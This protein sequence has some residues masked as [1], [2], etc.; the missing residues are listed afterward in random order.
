MFAEHVVSESVLLP[1]VGYVEMAMAFS[2]AS[3][4]A[5]DGLSFLRRCAFPGLERGPLA[6]RR[7]AL[8]YSEHIDGAFEIAS[9][10]EQS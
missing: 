4:P 6:K 3:Q 1:G 5:L 7:P 8:R 9:T 10:K 2:H